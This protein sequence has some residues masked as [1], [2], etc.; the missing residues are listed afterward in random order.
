MIRWIERV[1]LAAGCLLL[2][3]C[4]AA[5]IDSRYHQFAGNLQLDR[6]L[7][8]R[9]EAQAPATSPVYEPSHGELI[10]RV[11]VARLG[12]SAVVFE[13]TDDAV[14]NRGVGHL[15]G[16]A[17]PAEKSGNVVLAGHRDSFFRDLRNVRS[18][19]IVTVTTES[20]TRNYEIE[21]EKVVEPTE[22]SVEAPTDTPSLTLI[23]CYP[24]SFIG[25]AP[26]RYILRGEDVQVVAARVN[27]KPKIAP[28][29]P[30]AA[31]AVAEYRPSDDTPH[32]VSF[33]VFQD[34]GVD[35]ESE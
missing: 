1:L 22:V 18:G 4:A 13:G 34:S 24:F 15:T 31:A 8:N 32:Y 20:G 26:K 6:L 25:H 19:D 10:G 29:L 9:S 2:G 27:P 5:W 35:S 28:Q 21:S 33:A 3:Y 14:L 12:L 11:A 17:M 23:T 16:S 7:R 30:T